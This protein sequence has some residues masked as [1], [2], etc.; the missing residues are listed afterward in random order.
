MC[1]HTK[2]N[3]HTSGTGLCKVLKDIENFGNED[4]N[5][6]KQVP[7]F[8]I[9]IW[10]KMDSWLQM[11]L[12]REVHGLL[13]KD[14]LKRTSKA[15]LLRFLDYLWEG[16]SLWYWPEPLLEWR[17]YELLQGKE[18]QIL[19]KRAGEVLNKVSR[20][21]VCLQGTG[22]MILPG[23]DY[24]FLVVIGIKPSA[25]NKFGK[26]FYHWATFPTLMCHLLS[27]FIRKEI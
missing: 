21:Y 13:V 18:G 10:P 23:K 24:F 7:I 15:G 11:W 9:F 20:F 5:T 12:D 6:P 27:L 2:G 22:S 3:T 16:P 19:N 1:V 14:W 17:L 8:H 26:E 25:L 4:P